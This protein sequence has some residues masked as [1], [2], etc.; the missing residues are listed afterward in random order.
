M[1]AGVHPKLLAGV[2]SNLKDFRFLENRHTILTSPCLLVHSRS[3]HSV[4]SILSQDHAGHWEHEVN[5]HQL[6][7]DGDSKCTQSGVA[8]AIQC[9]GGRKHF[10]AK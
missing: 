9:Q 8:A 7:P 3:I 10:M 4:L 2:P 5:E 6:L 1:L